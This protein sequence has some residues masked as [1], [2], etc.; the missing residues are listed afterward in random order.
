M[1]RRID[2]ILSS[3]I[4]SAAVLLTMKFLGGSMIKPVG[5]VKSRVMSSFLFTDPDGNYWEIIAAA[6]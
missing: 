3:V 5:L 2:G 6:N 1:R 4:R